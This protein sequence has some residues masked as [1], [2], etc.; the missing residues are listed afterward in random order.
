MP[1]CIVPD[2]S[3]NNYSE[4]RDVEI[5]QNP[6]TQKIFEPGS[7][8]K[9]ITMAGA[10]NEQKLTPQ[11]TYLDTGEVKIGGWKITNYDNRIW[12]Q[13]TMTEVLEM[14]I[15]TGA[16]FAEKQ[17]GHQSFLE[18]VEKFGFFEKTGI[19]L[20][21]EVFS[22]NKEFKKGYE[23]NFATASFGQGIEITPI[24]LARAFSAIANGGKL[25]T[26]YILE[27][28]PPQNSET[29]VISQS[30]A[31]Q[32]TAMLVSVIENGFSKKAKI[33][34]YF[35]AGKTGTSQMPWPALGVQR[36]GYSS[37][38]WQSFIGFAPAFNPEFLILV[39]LDNP[40]RRTAEYSAMPI[41]R[42]LAKYII[43]YWEIPPDYE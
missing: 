10:L 17:L 20:Q 4:I 7:V 41:F 22:E 26:P 23:I 5:F 43:D 6:L 35:I 15:N 39:K 16:V 29:Q 40:Q 34:G 37:K 31:S 28:K 25:V 1:L 27:G 36:S 11:T 14:S 42:D 32:L 13:K 24:Q 9:P 8:F 30:T 38:T 19:D 18:Y 3:P 12:G 21:G 33:E 2:F